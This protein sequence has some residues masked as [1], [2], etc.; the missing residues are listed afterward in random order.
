[1]VVSERAVDLVVTNRS[2][3]TDGT[4]DLVGMKVDVLMTKGVVCLVVTVLIVSG[5]EVETVTEGGGDLVIT[6]GV[7]LAVLVVSEGPVD[8]VVTGRSVDLVVTGRS[9][10]LI[11]NDGAIDLVGLEKLVDLMGT[12]DMVV[13]EAAVGL[14]TADGMDTEDIKQGID[15]VEP[16]G[17]VVA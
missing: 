7:E 2:V 8:L 11:E 4:D 6:N 16:D 15:L 17:E 1:L 14:V 5:I 12:D 3:E 9:V 10:D 13:T